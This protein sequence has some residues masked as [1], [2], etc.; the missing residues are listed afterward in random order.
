LIIHNLPIQIT[1]TV[2]KEKVCSEF[3]TFTSR[4]AGAERIGIYLQRVKNLEQT[5]DTLN[6][7]DI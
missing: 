5:F 6:K 2:Y 3:L 4:D 1:G 7:P